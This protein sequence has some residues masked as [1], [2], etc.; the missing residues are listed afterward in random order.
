MMKI[1][2]LS[3]T[4]SE[5][6]LQISQQ[7]KKELPISQRTL[8][9]IGSLEEAEKMSLPIKEY[10]NLSRIVENHFKKVKDTLY[11]YEVITKEDVI[12]SLLKD[13]PESK[14]L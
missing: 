13:Q 8:E 3:G 10:Y 6:S 1:N 7:V 12:Q 14:L 11:K 4:S 2:D 9:I 5:D